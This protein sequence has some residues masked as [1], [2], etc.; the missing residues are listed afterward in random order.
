MDDRTK[1]RVMLPHWL[2]HNEGH[3]KE[4]LAWADKLRQAGEREAAEA[5]AQAAASLD[6][7]QQSLDE[8]LRLLGGPLEGEDRGGHH[9]HHHHGH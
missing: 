7:A 3:G 5:L 4:F 1:V 2:D 9:H 8:A 6:E